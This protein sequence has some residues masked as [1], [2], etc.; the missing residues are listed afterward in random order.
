MN[1]WNKRPPNLEE[2][3]LRA[4]NHSKMAHRALEAMISQ[5]E[6]GSCK[7]G[8]L[9][10]FF[11]LVQQ[12]DRELMEKEAILRFDRIQKMPP[13]DYDPTID[14]GI[15]LNRQIGLR[16]LREQCGVKI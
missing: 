3:V 1:A 15:E 16:Y 11:D 5:L 7:I 10:A 8:D 9:K 2:Q 6:A 12:N 14:R 4:R 13:D